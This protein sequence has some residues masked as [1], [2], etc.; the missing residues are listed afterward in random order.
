MG[1]ERCCT[2]LAQYIYSEFEL[3]DKSTIFKHHWLFSAPVNLVVDHGVI[4]LIGNA[5]QKCQ[6]FKGYP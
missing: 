6:H 4:L 3:T 5:P 2:I 1:F